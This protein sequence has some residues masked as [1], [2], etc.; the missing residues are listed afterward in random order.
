M[1]FLVAAGAAWLQFDRGWVGWEASR[2]A[3]LYNS[4]KPGPA[5]PYLTRAVSRTSLAAKPC[6]D[7]GDLAVWTVDDGAFQHFYRIDDA[8]TLLRLAFLSYAEA[9]NR[10]P[11][12]ARAWAGLAEVFKKERSLRL[13]DEA[14]DLDALS[15]ER[16]QSLDAEDRL[17]VAAYSRSTRLEPNNYFYHAYLGDF[18]DG[19]GLR[20]EALAAYARSIEIMP[21]LSWHY[22]LPKQDV[23]ADLYAAARGALERALVSNHLFLRERVWLNLADLA[24]RAGDHDTAV[25]AYRQAI[26][27]AADPSPYMQLLGELLFGLKRYDEAEKVLKDSI[28]RQSLQ[29]RTSGLVYALLGKC[30]MMRNDQREAVEYLKQ[31]RWLSPTVAYI[32]VELGQA[33]ESLGMLAQAEAEY[34]AAIRLEPN[35]ASVYA[36]L[37]AMYRRTHQISK[38]IA[39]ARRLVEMFPDNE[40]F[41]D[42]L[43]S[44]NRE[45]GRPEAG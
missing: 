30:A 44:L 14:V 17:V 21:D 5:Y 31:A 41:K 20:R 33:Y 24:E 18:Y 27:A 23:P 42:Q 38:A 39:L 45:I 22:Y 13:K 1:A 7:L 10:Q 2:G 16:P 4:G 36:E 28:S 32:G 34:E 40:I 12:S 29:S 15:G 9:L 43:R 6:L 3:E 25:D 19:R 26:A 35:K 11:G 37:I 8:R